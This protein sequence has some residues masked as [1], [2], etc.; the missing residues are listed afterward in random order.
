MRDEERFYK[1][2]EDL[3][4]MQAIE[5]RVHQLEATVV[6]LTTAQVA[7]TDDISELANAVE[8]LNELL[9]GDVRSTDSG[10]V[11]QINEQETK[12]TG[13]LRILHGGLLEQNNEMWDTYTGTK[14]DRKAFWENVVKVLIAVIGAI[15]GIV[16]LLEKWPDI[17]AKWAKENERGRIVHREIE[18]A[19]T[20]RRTIILQKVVPEKPEPPQTD[21]VP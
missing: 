4:R 7:S 9:H 16:L 8:G 11:G 2:E 12:L 14:Q 19:K 15:G 5:D 21:V 3:R 6:S 10:V 1:R 17:Q 18:R 13:V 20:K